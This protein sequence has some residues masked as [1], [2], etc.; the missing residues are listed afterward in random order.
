MR[1]V[2]DDTLTLVAL[3][4]VQPDAAAAE[5]LDGCDQCREELAS[6]TAVVAAGRAG[7]P[8]EAPAPGV[9]D[10]IAQEIASTTAEPTAA[11]PSAAPATPPSRRGPAGSTRPAGRRERPRG[12]LARAA[13]LAA[14]VAAGVVGTLVVTNL[15]PDDEPAPVAQAELD[16]L[17]GWQ[18]TGSASLEEVDGRLLLRVEVSG[19]EPDGFREVWLLDE[20]V[21]QLVSVGL[22]AGNEGVFDLP[23][24]LDLDELVL[25]DVSREPFDG[26]PAHSGDSIVRGRLTT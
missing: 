14:G 3:G 17:P 7:G 22:L 25:V 23:A 26:D 11:S 13:W 8:L 19:E 4:E 10:R 18:E 24:G 15:P 12:R 2:D 5:H 16:P 20:D 1:H 21:E 9:W 6:L